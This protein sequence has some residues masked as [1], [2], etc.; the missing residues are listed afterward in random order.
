[1]KIKKRLGFTL[2]EII[3]ATS[4][5]SILIFSTTTLFFRYHKLKSRIEAVRPFVF[6]RALFFEKM[7]DMSLTIDPET[8]SCQ[9]PDHNEYVSFTFCNGFK[10][11]PEISGKC[12]CQIFRN[13]ED[14]LVY[15]I[16]NDKDIHCKRTFLTNIVKFKPVLENDILRIEFTDKH[17]NEFSYDFLIGKVKGGNK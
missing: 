4:L 1:M 9:S 14:D 13:H 16:S 10:D 3:I 8:I 17:E 11:N 6:E 12:C 2:F 5:F 15:D 7:T